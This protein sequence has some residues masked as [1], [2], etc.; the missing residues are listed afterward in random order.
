MKMYRNYKITVVLKLALTNSSYSVIV[1]NDPLEIA[2][3]RRLNA[4]QVKQ[5]VVLQEK[6]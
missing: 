4:P 6:D 3:H 2:P 5:A 1:C